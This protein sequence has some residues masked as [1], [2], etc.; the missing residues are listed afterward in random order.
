M[1]PISLWLL[2]VSLFAVGLL[3]VGL[4]LWG[5]NRLLARTVDAQAGH[6][7]YLNDELARSQSR[8][9]RALKPRGVVV[10]RYANGGLAQDEYP[11]GQ[12]WKHDRVGDGSDAWLTVLD[13]QGGKLAQYHP[14]SWHQVEAGT[15]AQISEAPA[16]AAA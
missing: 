5:R 14:G 7:E 15:I 10:T 3:I 16:E 4:Q 13:L 9:R 2:A 11:D 6:L 1:D 8:R 12:S